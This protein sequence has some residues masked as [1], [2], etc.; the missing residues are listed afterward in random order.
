MIPFPSNAILLDDDQPV[1]IPFVAEYVPSDPPP[2]RIMI[3]DGVAIGIFVRLLVEGLASMAVDQGRGTDVTVV[4]FGEQ[5]SGAARSAT[6][7][8]YSIRQFDRAQL[9]GSQDRATM[10]VVV[11]CVA[12]AGTLGSSHAVA[13]VA[14][15]VRSA[16]DGRGLR[17][18]DHTV[19][20]ISSERQYGRPDD[21]NELT[22]C[23]V[24]VHASVYRD[25][26]DNI[27]AQPNGG[28]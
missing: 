12:D 9:P 2:T 17:Q 7:D 22:V 24:N 19:E 10:I 4:A 26:R 16:L 6:I 21:N 23:V 18:L 15:L 20:I 5:S 3:D 1:V 11:V 8:S 14:G 27:A 28:V 25:L 13:E